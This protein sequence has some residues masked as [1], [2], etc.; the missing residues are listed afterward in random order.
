MWTL[1]RT[2]DAILGRLTILTFF[3]K[4]IVKKRKNVVTDFI[5][6]FDK[7]EMPK[8]KYKEDSQRNQYFVIWDFFVIVALKSFI[9]NRRSD[10]VWPRAGVIFARENGSF[11][12]IM[13]FCRIRLFS[14]DK[15][16]S[17]KMYL[18]TISYRI[19]KTCNTNVSHH[20]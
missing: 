14:L 6:R 19:C 5:H 18:K 8:R 16:W 9:K 4:C 13:I 15:I 7:V 3:F 12:K 20:A 17:N 2:S 1:Y 10:T 11:G